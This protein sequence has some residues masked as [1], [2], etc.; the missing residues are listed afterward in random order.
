MW[1]FPG[2]T[3][4]SILTRL[5]MFDGYHIEF[6]ALDVEQAG[7]KR[8]DVD[9]DL[10]WC[11]RYAGNPS[12]T[13][14]Y[15]GKWFFDQQGWSKVTWWSTRKLW[16]SNYDGTPIANDHFRPYHGWTMCQIEQYRGTSSIGSVRQVDLNVTAA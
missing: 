6:L 2:A 4:S 5:A 16:D 8:G 14:I 12:P 15:T 3:T 1:C 10:L 7:L 9:R 13:W 11:D